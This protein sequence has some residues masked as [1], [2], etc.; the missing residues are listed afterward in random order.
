MKKLLAICLF[1]WYNSK[2]LKNNHDDGLAL[3]VLLGECG[4]LEIIGG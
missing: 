1:L 4:A 3:R 2:R